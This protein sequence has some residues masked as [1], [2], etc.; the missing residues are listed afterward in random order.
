MYHAELKYQ[1]GLTLIKGIGNVLAKNLVAYVGSAEGVFSER[2]KTLSKIPGIGEMLSREIVKQNV[3][4]RAEEEVLFIEKNKIQCSFFTDR[5]YPYRLKECADSP[6]LLF[7]RGNGMLN[8]GKFVG[9]VGTRNATEQG[10]E[11]CKN[12]IADLAGLQPNINIVS[13]LAYGID[14]CAHKAT[15]ELGL[16]TIGVL[17]HGLDRI[18]PS[19]HRSV[20]VKILENGLLLT[21]YLSNTTPDKP[22]FVQRNRIIAGLCDA[23]VVVESGSK[24]GSLITAV[25]ANDYNRDVF[26]F[27]GRVT[28]E[29]SIGCNML[30]KNNQAALIESGKDMMRFMSW[31]TGEKKADQPTQTALFV[32]MTEEEIELLSVLRRFPDGIQVN[33]FIVILK[34]PFN[35][36]SALLLNMEF[37]GW[38]K[39]LPGGVYKATI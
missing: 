14:I 26:A 9:I 35:K 34:K 28:D 27:P 29:L 8:T 36:I 13:G 7:S 19:I 37:S 24:G 1:I 39:C 18:Y 32:D 21:E 10:K 25:M 20:A 33:E 17:G 6:V 16:P 12:L 31:E 30:I 11:N 5:D 3:L 23:V 15:L 38:V 22:N 2:Q 4:E